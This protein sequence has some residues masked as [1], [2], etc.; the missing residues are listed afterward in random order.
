MTL[1][2]ILDKAGPL[3][4]Q[5]A[6]KTAPWILAEVDRWC[7]GDF[8]GTTDPEYPCCFCERPSSS[9]RLLLGVSADIAPDGSI[10]GPRFHTVIP[11][12]WLGSEMTSP[13]FPLMVCDDCVRAYEAL[14]ME[15]TMTGRKR[16]PA[17]E[18]LAEVRAALSASGDP[19]ADELIMEITRRFSL[20]HPRDVRRGTCTLCKKNHPKVVQGDAAQL[21]GSCLETA[22]ETLRS[23]F[24]DK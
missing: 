21:C 16:P 9:S 1:R 20:A 5:H 13:P 18:V 11:P 6:P 17:S 14:I 10:R 7:A 19:G 12:D 3:I 23:A 15:D 4:R 2:E 8:E 22:R 24:K